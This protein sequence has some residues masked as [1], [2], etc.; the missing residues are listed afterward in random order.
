MGFGTDEQLLVDILK[1]KQKFDYNI[2]IETGTSIL[3]SNSED[4]FIFDI[5]TSELCFARLARN[6]EQA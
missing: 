1:Y 6:I 4:V 2:I 3:D 5:T